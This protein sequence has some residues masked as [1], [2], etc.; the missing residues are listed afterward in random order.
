LQCTRGDDS[1]ASPEGPVRKEHSPPHHG[2]GF[3]FVSG[4]LC[5]RL[6]CGDAGVLGL[7]EIVALGIAAL[8]ALYVIRRLTGW[9]RRKRL[10]RPEGRLSSGLDKARRNRRRR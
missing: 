2:F 5:G 8:A 3:P 6:A 1:W 9:P 10:V 7:Q 4:D